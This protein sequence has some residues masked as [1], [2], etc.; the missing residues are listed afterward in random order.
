MASNY[1]MLIGGVSIFFVSLF[2]AG[3]V[4]AT[5]NGDH[6]HIRK[7]GNY[8]LL[9]CTAVFIIAGLIFSVVLIVKAF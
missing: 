4:L 3:T 9:L 7:V 6:P 8:L 2:V 1:V 5:S